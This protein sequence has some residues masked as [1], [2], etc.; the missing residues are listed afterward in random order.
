MQEQKDVKTSVSLSD[1][2]N[3]VIEWKSEP[4]WDPSTH[5]F[6][7]PTNTLPLALYQFLLLKLQTPYKLLQSP[8]E[9][10]HFFLHSTTFFPLTCELSSCLLSVSISLMCTKTHAHYP[11]GSLLPLY[12]ASSFMRCFLLPFLMILS[13]VQHGGAWAGS[14]AGETSLPQIQ[15][16]HATVPLTDKHREGAYHQL[17]HVNSKRGSK[18]WKKKNP[19]LCCTLVCDGK[20]T[21]HVYA[22]EPHIHC[23]P[24]AYCRYS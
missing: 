19:K 6:L 24:A 14:T 15:Y 3:H 1:T 9:L 2:A 21:I 8:W 22:E 16:M 4:S 23:S 13:C 17:P 12:T 7:S 5:L 11:S 18:S 20:M 10:S